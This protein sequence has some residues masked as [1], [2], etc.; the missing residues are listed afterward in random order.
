MISNIEI[1]DTV[2]HWHGQYFWAK[3]SHCHKRHLVR[4]LQITV[5]CCY[6]IKF[7]QP[8]QNCF[9]TTICA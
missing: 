6:N 9:V 4:N 3:C 5:N 1:W 2:N 8:E 7:L